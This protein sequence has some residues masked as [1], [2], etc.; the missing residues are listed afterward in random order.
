V[1]T[2]ARSATWMIVTLSVRFGGT[3]EPYRPILF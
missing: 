2:P 1:L 3:V